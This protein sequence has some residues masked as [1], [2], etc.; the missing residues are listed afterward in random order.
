MRP[1]SAAPSMVENMTVPRG[2]EVHDWFGKA[3]RH[4]P[5]PELV[6]ALRQ[7]LAGAQEPIEMRETRNC[8][9]MA[10]RLDNRIDEARTV[11]FAIIADEPKNPRGY[12][13]LAN[14]EL[15][16]ADALQAMAAIDQAIVLANA[17]GD[18]RR[19][20]LGVKG[21][22]ALKL[23]RFDILE[24]VLRDIMALRFERRNVDIGIERDFLD[25]APA[26]AIDPELVRAYD[27][28]PEKHRA[29]R[30]A[31]RRKGWFGSLHQIADLDY[32]QRTWLN[33]PNPS[34]HWS[35]EGFR[36][37]VPNEHELDAGRRRGLLTEEEHAIMSSVYESV[38]AYE[39]PGGKEYDHEA[40]LAD[41]AWH[42]VVAKADA[43]RRRLLEL[44]DDPRERCSLLGE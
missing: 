28:Y 36:E 25:R 22:I 15:Y 5:I 24:S 2:F 37:D 39:P 26:G 41:P 42:A 32:Q 16:D 9:A 44:T 14:F 8:L 34:P 13:S 10:L 33:P 29:E 21:R 1:D 43:A 27:A 20:A 6:E 35:H 31:V 30:T 17:S 19:E 40:I 7:R 3:L 12:I 23:E 38:A 4:T 11:L 18:F